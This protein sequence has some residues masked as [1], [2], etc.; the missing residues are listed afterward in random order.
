[1]IRIGYI[2]VPG[3]GKT[4]AARALAGTIRFHTNFKTVELV[5]EYARVY[6]NKYGIDNITD[7]VNIL[8]KQLNK[9]NGYPS[10]TD[11]LITDSPIF[12]GFG[13][14]LDLRRE[15]SDKDTMILNDLFKSMNKLNQVPR[16]DIIFHLPPT[17]TPVQ[18]GIRLPHHF[19]QE[20]RTEADQKILSI[21]RIFSPRKL[22][23]LKSTLVT[24]RINESISIIKEYVN[25]K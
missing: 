22:V 10:S 12:L 17:L 9:E 25:T 15:G 13:Y 5:S 19:D 23:T 6:I 1:M 14:A 21:F 3:S 2:G 18:D 11:V 4:T 7:Q 16:Y 24:D 8:G 20:W